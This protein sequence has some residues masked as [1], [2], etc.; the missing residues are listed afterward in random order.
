MMRFVLAIKRARY[1]TMLPKLSILALTSFIALSVTSVRSEIRIADLGGQS[2]M[3]EQGAICA[4]FAALMENQYL[5]N[6]DLGALWSERRKF[7]GAVIRR[8]VE[9][10]GG[11]TP[12]SEDID[13]LINEYHEWLLLNLTTQ[14]TAQGITDYQTDIQ[15]L[16]ST[17]CVS[18]FTQADKAIVNRFP[19]L[20]YL[21]DPNFDKRPAPQQT[22]NAV[23]HAQIESLLKKNNELNAQILALK[24]ANT[25]LQ[26][27]NALNAQQVASASETSQKDK[28]QKD[29]DQ[30]AKIVTQTA[31]K[32]LPK[33]P[34]P[35]PERAK[36]EKQQV[37]KPSAVQ[38]ISD[39]NR[40]F[41][42]LG[43][44]SSEEI[45]NSAISELKDRYAG[46][47]S[48]LDLTVQSHKFSSGKIFYRVKTS[49]ASR[50]RITAI[51]DTL[52]E[53]RLG[54]LI[55]TNS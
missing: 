20:V 23:D 1:F 12:A 27:K 40:F 54:C 37:A 33:P 14:D 49:G 44:Y 25:E 3:A 5:I 13:H 45:A 46:L 18:L 4:S 17:N 43:S 6:P 10:S 9:L 26:V 53:A 35:R 15:N 29:T 48:D 47:F 36:A 21:A 38:T 34:A 32:P 51:C 19:N 8:A 39:Q 31:K 16:I 7:S 30:S 55:K 22:D 52:W 42:Q 41:A 50:Q 24:A 11:A 28:G 2:T